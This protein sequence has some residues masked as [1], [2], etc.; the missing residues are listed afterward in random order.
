MNTFA[1]NFVAENRAYTKLSYLSYESHLSPNEGL[2]MV[3]KL[4]GPEQDPWLPPTILHATLG[5]EVQVV[6]C[7]FLLMISN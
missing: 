3:L 6:D 4:K 7:F 2:A 1:R 5:L